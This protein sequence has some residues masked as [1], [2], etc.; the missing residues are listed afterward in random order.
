M[1]EWRA[2]NLTLV[3]RQQQTKKCEKEWGI[4]HRRR[5]LR[6]V[7]CVFNF[8]DDDSRHKTQVSSWHFSL[9]SHSISLSLLLYYMFEMCKMS[10]R[11]DEQLLEQIF[12]FILYS[13]SSS[14]SLLSHHNHHTDMDGWMNSMIG[15]RSKQQSAKDENM[16]NIKYKSFSLNFI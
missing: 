12:T 14:S 5:S 11:R 10:G 16:T 1:N 2:N 13:F 9:L 4:W 15:W 8:N 3:L 6:V 7:F